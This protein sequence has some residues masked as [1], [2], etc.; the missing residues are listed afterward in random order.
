MSNDGTKGLSS[1]ASGRTVRPA[2]V[3]KPCPTCP[4]RVDQ[5]ADEIPNFSLELAERLDRTVGDQFG[6]PI[7]ACHQSRE[8]GE[9]VCVGWLARYGWNSIAV[10]LMLLRG[11]L[12]PEQLAV[13]KDWPELHETF[14]EVI[15]KLRADCEAV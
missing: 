2:S 1:A 13:G 6:D 10:R 11:A 4:W 15:E 12:K 9:V 14:E 7:F 8:G 5:H 3:R